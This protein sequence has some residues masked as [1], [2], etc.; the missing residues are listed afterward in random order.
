MVAGVDM[1]LARVL[2]MGEVDLD[3]VVPMDMAMEIIMVVTADMGEVAE[4]AGA[5][6]DV[7]MAM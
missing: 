3:G 7:H 6:E 4:V 1:V 2:H 5:V